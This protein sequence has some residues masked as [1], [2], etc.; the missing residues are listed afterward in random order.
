MHSYYEQ[1]D[2]INNLF[3]EVVPYLVIAEQMFSFK[4]PRTDIL[5][6]NQYLL[7]NHHRKLQ[8]NI[9]QRIVFLHNQQHKIEQ[10]FLFFLL[11]KVTVTL[12]NKESSDVHYYYI[13]CLKG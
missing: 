4:H 2:T 11:I 3:L 6:Q 13:I 12:S 7:T 8:C 10:K 1:G 5:K 9:K